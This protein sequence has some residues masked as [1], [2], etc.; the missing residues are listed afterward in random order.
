MQDKAGNALFFSSGSFT[1]S[2]S[3]AT[4]DPDVSKLLLIKAQSLLQSNATPVAKN[5][6]AFEVRGDLNVLNSV[7]NG[8]VTTPGGAVLQP[9]NDYWGDIFDYDAEY[10]SKT[11]MDRFFANGTYAVSLNTAHDGIK[12]VPLTFPADAYPNDPTLSNFSGLQAI[13]SAQNLTVSWG[14]FSGADATSTYFIRLRL[15][16]A[17]GEDVYESP[18]LGQ[19]GAL[20]GTS[21]SVVIPAN[22]LSPGRKYEG[23]LVFAKIVAKDS[24][25]YSGVTFRALFAKATEFELQTTGSPIRP[26]ITITKGGQMKIDVTG[27]K[28]VNYVLEATQDFQSW[29]A[30]SYPQGT[31]S[32][33]TATFF[34]SDSSYFSRRFY[35]VRE[36]SSN[37][38]FRRPVSVQGTV[39][40]S[41]NSAPIAGATVSTTLS[42]TTTTT[43]SN[44]RFFLQTDATLTDYNQSYGITVSKAGY[45]T[46]SQNV[47]WGESP[48]NL[49]IYLSP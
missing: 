28:H 23:E 33:T 3:A 32:G 12:N 34:D 24:T 4:T 9:E 21:T 47:S 17:S 14:A 7:L 27:D 35:R 43:D 5:V 40:Q 36:E 13:N 6:Y 49:E 37:D 31:Y 46:Y 45:S 38:F 41:N 19:P 42:G 26:T 25:T 44:G 20:L 30:I 8:T 10:A 2:G 39:Y 22:T 11:D 48:R 29:F 16:T 15:Q 1:T 18:D